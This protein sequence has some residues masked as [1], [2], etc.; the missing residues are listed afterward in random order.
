MVLYRQSSL[1]H[2]VDQCVMGH[3]I[4]HCLACKPQQI[5]TEAS[6]LHFIKWIGRNQFNKPRV[7][8]LYM[9]AMRRRQ[10]LSSNKVMNFT[11]FH[12]SF[13]KLTFEEQFLGSSTQSLGSGELR[14]PN[15]S[16]STRKTI[17]FKLYIH[18]LF[19][20]IPPLPDTAHRKN[21]AQIRALINLDSV[22]ASIS[23]RLRA[24][25]QAGRGTSRRGQMHSLGSRNSVR[26]THF[27]S[28]LFHRFHRNLQISLPAPKKEILC[29]PHFWYV[30]LE[31]LTFRGMIWPLISVARSLWSVHSQ[32]C[33]RPAL[34]TKA[35]L[36]LHADRH[37]PNVSKSLLCHLIKSSFS[38]VFLAC[39]IGFY[40]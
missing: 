16:P 26:W 38:P 17:W 2:R 40:S 4:F 5:D 24:L 10:L 18:I 23:T 34:K 3:I 22:P 7:L 15:Q 11:S 28:W 33:S 27:H 37:R 6:N 25:H 1:Y 39:K 29:C 21:G 32:A 14:L 13:S 30:L 31:V 35:V 12:L 36:S 19:F 9:K 20:P 8:E